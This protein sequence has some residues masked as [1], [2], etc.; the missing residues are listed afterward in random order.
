[1]GSCGL[2]CSVSANLVSLI[3]KTRSYLSSCCAV[4]SSVRGGDSSFDSPFGCCGSGLSNEKGLEDGSASLGDAFS[5]SENEA[6]LGERAIANG[7]GLRLVAEGEGTGILDAK[8]RKEGTC[9]C[10]S[11][12][13]FFTTAGAR[14][15]CS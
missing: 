1:M 2:P 3:A 5:A 10:A 4:N 13:C 15:P 11:E 8:D 9:M 12:D 6:A 14:P 7:G